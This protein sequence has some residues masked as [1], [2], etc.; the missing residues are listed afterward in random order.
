MAS[1]PMQ[2]PE[3]SID[4]QIRKKKFPGGFIWAVCFKLP[5]PAVED[6]HI[7]QHIVQTECG[8]QKENGS[9]VKNVDRKIQYWEAWEVKKG[10]TEPRQTQTTRTFVEVTSKITVP[11]GDT[12]VEWDVPM[13]DIFFRKYPLGAKGTYMIN[14]LAGFY[15][16]PLTADFM[17]GHA[18]TGAGA[19]KSTTIKPKFWT[20]IGLNRQVRFNYF[21]ETPEEMRDD[22]KQNLNGETVKMNMSFFDSWLTT[23][24]AGA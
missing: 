11:P 16:Q 1:A 4:K 24:K 22:S 19:L 14:G 8:T 9:I 12:S 23:G 21:C 5:S 15:H 20:I 3:I 7:I 6:G 18:E 13:N 2:I 17:I 10:E